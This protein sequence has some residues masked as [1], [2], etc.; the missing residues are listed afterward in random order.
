[1]SVLATDKR[2]EKGSDLRVARMIRLSSG[3]RRES[4]SH[5]HIKSP[6]SQAVFSLHTI[7]DSVHVAKS[8][9]QRVVKIRG[10]HVEL[11]IV[12][13]RRLTG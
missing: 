5:G 7:P 11:S 13:Y 3:L 1:M 9:V 8:L 6:W 10:L 4:T 2:N 12:G